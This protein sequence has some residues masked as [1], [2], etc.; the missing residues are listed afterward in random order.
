MTKEK[1]FNQKSNVLLRNASSSQQ[2]L[3]VEKI[4]LY[5]SEL[6]VLGIVHTIEHSFCFKELVI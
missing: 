6:K 5:F 4:F 3:E 2:S 1:T